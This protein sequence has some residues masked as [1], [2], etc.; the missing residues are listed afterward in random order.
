MVASTFCAG[1]IKYLEASREL[2][3]CLIV[4][5]NT[6]ASVRRLKGGRPILDEA[7][8]AEILS[9]LSCVD[10]VVLFEEDTPIDLIEEIRPDVLTKGAIP[11][12]SGR[13]GRGIWWS[14]TAAEWRG[15]TS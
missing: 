3:D 6:D 15:S 13:S 9:A 8:R 10:Y 2:G 12:S 4:G 14:H 5:L 11:L 7:E 1:H